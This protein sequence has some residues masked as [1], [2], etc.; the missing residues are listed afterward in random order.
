[1]AYSTDVAKAEAFARVVHADQVDKAGV[2]YTEHLRRVAASVNG[3]REKVVAWLHDTVEDADVSIEQIKEMFGIHTAAAVLAM[4]RNKGEDY[5]VYVRRIKSNRVARAVKIAD[6]IDN[7]NLSRILA[8]R[9]VTS[10][11]AKRV[12]KYARALNILFDN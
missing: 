9:K 11:D 6:L 8:V 12:A 1:M 7:L 4:T 5:F 2:A 3:N 10:E